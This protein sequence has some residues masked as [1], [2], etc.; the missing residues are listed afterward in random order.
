MTIYFVAIMV[1]MPTIVSADSPPQAQAGGKA[2]A[3]QDSSAEWTYTVG[4]VTADTSAWAMG[5]SYGATITG[6]VSLS[7]L[8]YVIV[9]VLFIVGALLVRLAFRG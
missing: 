2:T 1:A 6:I 7:S 4:P 8:I 3:G 9:G 5:G